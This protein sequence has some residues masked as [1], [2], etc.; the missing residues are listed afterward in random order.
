MKWNI[1]L[2]YPG[3]SEPRNN[4]KI[5]SAPIIL[6]LRGLD[7]SKIINYPVA[8]EIIDNEKIP[9]IKANSLLGYSLDEC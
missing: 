5:S 9:T 8:F 1:T 7:C 4:R 2:S 6:L 3:I